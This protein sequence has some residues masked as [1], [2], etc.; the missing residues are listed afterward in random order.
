MVYRRNVV[1]R[2]H[3]HKSQLIVMPMTGET[4]ICN[5]RMGGIVPRTTILTKRFVFDVAAL[6]IPIGG[7][8]HHDAVEMVGEQ[9]E[10]AVVAAWVW[11]ERLECQQRSGLSA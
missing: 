2:I 10:Q 9:V 1:A 4:H 6:D 5:V 7:G 8:D 3:I 11:R